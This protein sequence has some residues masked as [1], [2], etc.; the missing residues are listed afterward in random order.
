MLWTCLFML[1]AIG[2]LKLSNLEYRAYRNT[3]ESHEYRAG[4]GY[5]LPL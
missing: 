5:S 3:L 1:F 4:L 2:F